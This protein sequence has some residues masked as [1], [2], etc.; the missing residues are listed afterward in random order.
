MKDLFEGYVGIRLWDGQVMNDLLFTLLLAL[1]F[2]FALMFRFNYRAFIKML[3]DVVYIKER[4]SLFEKKISSDYYF[5]LFMIFQTLFLCSMFAF[6]YLSIGGYLTFELTSGA[7]TL[8]IAGIFGITLLFYCIK[9]FLY[10]MTAM[11]FSDILRYNIW[12]NSYLA[13]M[14]TWGVLLYIPV[15]WSTLWGAYPTAPV[16]LFII[17][18]I[19]SRIA[20]AYKTFRIFHNKNT[21][22]FYI[23][24][25]LCV[26]EILPLVFLYE[27]MV[28]LYNFIK[29]STLWH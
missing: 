27:G 22:L 18:Y 26:Q 12:K 29:T 21:G 23:S 25:Y 19:L 28:Y 1:L 8:C 9:R 5:R 3:Q 24:L 10:L 16:F 7:V 4:Q 15:A 20:I 14:G 11:I 6:S 17:F 13:I 2:L